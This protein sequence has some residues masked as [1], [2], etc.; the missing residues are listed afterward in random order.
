MHDISADLSH[1][2][3]RPERPGDHARVDD[4]VRAA[5]MA[6]FNSASEVDLV[7]AL[8][9]RGELI[10]D[11]TLV[12]V[13]A[14]QIVGYI[15]FSEVTL[16]GRPARGLGLAPVAVAPA[17]Q[18]AGVGSRLIED[19]L[20]RA[21]RAGWQF[22]VL[23]GHHDYYPRFGFRPAAPLGLTGDYGDH[24]GWMVR[25]LD[26]AALPTGHARYCS[27]FLV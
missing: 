3:I 18:G 14:G 9:Q 10:G 16:D 27:A 11:L 22:V 1:L 20:Q 2:E 17:A 6:E 8:R 13:V 21:E 25:A 5:F 19:A 15:A 7:R 24:D 12:A 26:D 23:L 4:V